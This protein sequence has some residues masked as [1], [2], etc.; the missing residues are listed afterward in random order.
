MKVLHLI[1]GGDRGGAKTHIKSLMKGLEG[2]IYTKLICFT[3][4]NFYD[5][6][7]NQGI[8][9]QVFQQKNRFDMSIISRL[10][11][12]IS[13]NNYDIIH[14]H[15]ARANFIAML[16]KGVKKPFVTTIHS[17]YKLDF[18]DKTYKKIIFTNLNKLALKG[19]NYYIAISDTFKDM[20]VE[21]GFR[22]DKIYVAYNGIDMDKEIEFIPRDEFLNRYSIDGKDRTIV[23]I[24]GRLDLVKKHDTFIKAAARVLQLRRDVVFL[25]A[26]EGPEEKRLTS[27][28][29]ELGIGGNIHFLGFIGD[30]YSFFNAIDI[31]VLT[32]VS[33][34][35]PYVIL[36]GARMKKPIIS[37]RVG[38]ITRLIRDDYNGYIIDV[39]D[40]KGLSDKI[41]A[42]LDNQEK[43]IYM[44]ENL[45]KGV[46]ENFSAKSM[47]EEHIRIYTEILNNMED[48]E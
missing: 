29:Q 38:G 28:V 17:D 7:K 27:M 32:S 20:L 4:D 43:I 14:C 12:E 11:D 13:E 34:S 19:F 18:T 30:A 35:F 42:L 9:I 24:M 3:R 2:R 5:E 21:R 10:R 26:G 36:E 47:A 46:E 48:K 41:L 45:Y 25:I 44:G 16:L 15:G 33:E 39:D 40:E 23:G 31:N 8:R 1:S 22:A 37:T 6:L